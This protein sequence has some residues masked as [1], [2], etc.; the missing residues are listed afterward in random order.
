M[1]LLGCPHDKIEAS[2]GRVFFS[3]AVDPGAPRV[4]AGQ[5]TTYDGQSYT[6]EVCALLYIYL[7]VV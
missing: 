6:D 1:V 7:F 2:K 5:S 3:G 4:L